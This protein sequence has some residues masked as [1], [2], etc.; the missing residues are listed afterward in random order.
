MP[1]IADI[2]WHLLR[3]MLSIRPLLLQ[4]DAGAD[5]LC[6]CRHALPPDAEG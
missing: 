6:R 2:R 5:V 1:A 3:L 4:H